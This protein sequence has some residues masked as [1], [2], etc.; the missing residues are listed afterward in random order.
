MGF[1][2]DLVALGTGS[3]GERG[4]WRL[5]S[6]GRWGLVLAAP[7]ATAVARAGDDL[8]LAGPGYVESVRLAAVPVAMPLP[9]DWTALGAGLRV[10]AVARATDGRLAVVTSG[11]DALRCF[12]AGS[13]GVLRPLTPGPVPLYAQSVAWLDDR[14]LLLL[15]TDGTGASLLREVEV[16]AGSLGRSGSVGGIRDFGLSGDGGTLAAVTAGSILIG[17]PAQ[18][19]GGNY[20]RVIG[21]VPDGELAWAVALDPNGSSVAVV[22]ASVG[23]DG[24]ATRPHV[25]VY[26]RGAGGWALR[27]DAQMPF[28]TVTGLAWAPRGAS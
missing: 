22:E 13:G 2:E 18:F 23:D 21:G 11:S 7:T 20:P 10:A 5:D 17:V 27:G 9:L 28:D 1:A 26:E 6:S 15:A 16:T 12:V 4:I 8:L 24:T 25:V 14:H 19:L 3:T